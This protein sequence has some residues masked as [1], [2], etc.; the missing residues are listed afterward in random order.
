MTQPTVESLVTEFTGK[1][2]QRLDQSKLDGDVRLDPTRTVVLLSLKDKGPIYI[3]VNHQINDS[4]VESVL[5]QIQL[6][7]SLTGL[8]LD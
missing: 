1:I 4:G 3:H 8:V 5:H 2:A 6:V 7:P